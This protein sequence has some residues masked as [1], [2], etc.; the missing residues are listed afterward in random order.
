METAARRPRRAVHDTARCARR[1][2][3]V[4]PGGPPVWVGGHSDATLRQALRF[5]DGSYGTGDSAA[6]ITDVQRRL[7]ELADSPGN[8]GR[9][10]LAAAAFLAPPGIPAASASTG[11]AAGGTAPTAASVADDLGQLAG[12]GSRPTRCGCP[13]QLNTWR[14][15]W[16]GSLPRSCRSSPENGTQARVWRASRSDSCR[17]LRQVIMRVDECGQHNQRHI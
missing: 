17:S 7:R 12:A 4:H 11:T 6:E 2:A 8:A 9:L 3:P 14:G 5:G 10:T 15:R 16:N 13:S 1:S